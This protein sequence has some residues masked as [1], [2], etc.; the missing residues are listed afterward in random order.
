MLKNVIIL[1]VSFLLFVSLKA[2]SD[3]QVSTQSCYYLDGTYSYNGYIDGK[4]SYIF[5]SVEVYVISWNGSNWLIYNS[6]NPGD[7]YYSNTAN[8]P[9]PPC[10]GWVAANGGCEAI[11]VSGG[12]SVNCPDMDGDGFTDSACGG[13]DCND[14]DH[15]INP[16][17]F[18]ICNSWVDDDCD[19]LADDYDFVYY[20]QS[21]F[22][23][24][25]DYD[26]YG[27][28]DVIFACIQPDMTSTNYDDCNDYEYNINPA[29][30]EFCN[31]ID[32]DCD[33]FVDEGQLSP[34]MPD[35]DG[36]GFGA[37]E[38]LWACYQP[39]GYV[40]DCSFAVAPVCDCD[41]SNFNINPAAPEI[42]NEGIDDDCNGYAD[43]YDY[44]VVGQTNYYIDGDGDGY[45]EG[46]I[47]SCAQYSGYVL[48]G[49]DC[50]D[51]SA[52]IYPGA[53]EE[54]N[55]TD[56][57]CDGVADNDVQSFF[58]PDMD[59]D[60]FG[61]G[62]PI[63]TCTQ[64]D[65]TSG[66]NLDCDDTNSAVSPVAQEICNSGVDDDCDGQSDDADGSVT[67]QNLYYTDADS[68]G[69]GAGDLIPACIQPANTSSTN[70]DCNDDNSSINPAATEICNSGVDDDCNIATAD[71][72]YCNCSNALMSAIV[73][74]S[75]TERMAD[76]E[77][78]D[79]D[80]T[81]YFDEDGSNLYILLSIK[82]EGQPIG[83]IGDG[84]FAV[85]QK[86]SA[87]VTIIPNNYPVNYCNTL[88]WHVMNRY[89]EVEPTIQPTA[90]VNV[91]FYYTTNDFDALV[92]ALETATPPRTLTS[93]E[94]MLFYKVEDLLGNG[95]DINPV[96][97]H[98]DIPISSGYGTD[99]YYEYQHSQEADTYTWHHEIF[100]SD[101]HY[102]EYV[103][104]KFSGGGG[105]G[106]NVGGAFPIELLYFTGHAEA[107]ANILK[108]ATAT[109][110]NN[111]FQIIERSLNGTDDWME[112]GRV[113]GAG[114]S[115]DEISY[116]LQ[117]E[118]PP[119]EAYYHLRAVDFNGAEQL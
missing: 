60:G 80:W 114:N 111:Q 99:G 39:P 66:N 67:G 41:D 98:I 103:V 16:A 21:P 29:A 34:F 81:H 89:W 104:S 118:N 12:C 84:T 110:R 95:Y 93:H 6:I 9:F 116:Q 55:G 14:Y 70:D 63:Q 100:N 48:I 113:T 31:E 25:S 11:S 57:D 43:D 65:N 49:G 50:Y 76:M 92:L 109:E 52:D 5:L 15:Y 75:S 94:Q 85:R 82:K 10:D 68:D 1:L 17:A 23:Y 107:N 18:E 58:Y 3:V 20:G 87:G 64:P 90:G 51:A 40:P 37:G 46:F 106:G 119:I 79:G 62:D 108:W 69:Y 112:I 47:Q 2:Q 8:T 115:L 73:A 71:P 22:Y 44:N 56:E 83:N 61:A 4:P 72:F 36:D 32:D 77:C 38:V 74:P 24:D 59:G 28:F 13:D 35:Y 54:C 91:R 86:G 78:I 96:N 42:C 117:D 45:G 33:G 19:G 102:G 26:G 105:G 53:P 30:Q 88:N 97:G 7:H 27:S 101:Y